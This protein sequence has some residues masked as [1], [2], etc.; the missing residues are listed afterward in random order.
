MHSVESLSQL[1]NFIKILSEGPKN[2]PLETILSHSNLIQILITYLNMILF[3]IT[4][5]HPD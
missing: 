4:L 1:T 5:P 2:V 3:P